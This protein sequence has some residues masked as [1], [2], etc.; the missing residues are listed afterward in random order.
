[1]DLESNIDKQMDQLA[2]EVVKKVI[3][4]P[5]KIK[6]PKVGKNIEDM[7]Q[8]WLSKGLSKVNKTAPDPNSISSIKKKYLCTRKEAKEILSKIGV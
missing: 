1:M 5:V 8:K 7:Y 4:K 2:D 3:R 6:N